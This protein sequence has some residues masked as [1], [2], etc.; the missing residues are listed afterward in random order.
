VDEK[1]AQHLLS[2]YIEFLTYDTT[3]SATSFTGGFIMG[4]R[5]A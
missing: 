2:E 5:S 3:I 4:L 1:D